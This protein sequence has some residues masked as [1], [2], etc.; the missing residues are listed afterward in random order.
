MK[1]LGEAKKSR[2]T[3]NVSWFCTRE[4]SCVSKKKRFFLLYH[5]KD[6]R[7]DGKCN[8]A[9]FSLFC[10]TPFIHHRRWIYS[11]DIT[12]VVIR[13]LW[14]EAWC[15]RMDFI[16]G[17]TFSTRSFA[18]RCCNLT[19]RF[20]WNNTKSFGMAFI[21]LIT[22]HRWR[23]KVLE[24]SIL[25]QTFHQTFCSLMMV[26]TF[27]FLSSKVEKKNS[28]FII[29]LTLQGSSEAL[30]KNFSVPSLNF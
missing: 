12:M 22:L 6:S 25:C 8:G 28:Y 15:E 30:R 4:S 1:I 11:R 3:F 24:N 20:H 27:D 17:E 14:N 10:V 5:E 7:R 29:T 26:A 2:N 21:S 18:V 19:S 23:W 13:F 16:W 9:L